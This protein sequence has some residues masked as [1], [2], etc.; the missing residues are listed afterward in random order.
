MIRMNI[1]QKD[2]I[3]KNTNVNTKKDI[4]IIPQIL[5]FVEN[6]DR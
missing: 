2:K 3:K 6:I 5:S 1:I 4:K